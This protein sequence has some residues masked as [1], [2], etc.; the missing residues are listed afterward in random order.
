MNTISRYPVVILAGGL[1]TRLRPLTEK[2]PKALIDINGEPFIIHQLRLLKKQGVTSVV[3][4]LGYLGEKVVEVINNY[5]DKSIDIHY[6]FDGP[7]LLGTAGAI[8]K[9]IPHI[10][11]DSFFVLYGDSYLPC[12]FA[13]VQHT[14]LASQKM[15]LMTVFHNK[16]Q[17]DASNIAFDGTHILAYDKNKKTPHMHYIDYGLGIFNKK[18]FAAVPN[19]GPYDLAKLY[20]TLLTQGQLA[21]CLVKERFYEIGSLAGINEL[22]Y[23]LR[24]K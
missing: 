7:M 12:D 15:A 24:E 6:C 17:W 23:Y 8:K 3:L 9:A 20:Q 21:A 5:T 14:Y 22:R 18:V 13:A 19:H 10:P 4:C 11:N 2:I 1:A 16:G